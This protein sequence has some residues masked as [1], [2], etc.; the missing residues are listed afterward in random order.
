MGKMHII[1]I[2]FCAIIILVNSESDWCVQ[3]S[4]CYACIKSG[5]CTWSITS[6]HNAICIN[7]KRVHNLPIL[8]TFNDPQSCDDYEIL[9]GML[10]FTCLN[11]ELNLITNKMSEK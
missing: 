10:Q 3:R 2:L 5:S 8:M 4:Y 1:S 11:S 9:K 7:E 6:H